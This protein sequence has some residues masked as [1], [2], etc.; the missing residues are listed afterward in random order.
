MEVLGEKE[1]NVPIKPG[2]LVCQ[3]RN[4]EGNINYFLKDTGTHNDINVL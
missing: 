4:E 1:V 2:A 3:N